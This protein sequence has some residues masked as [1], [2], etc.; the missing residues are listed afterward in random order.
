LGDDSPRRHKAHEV[1]KASALALSHEVIG[2]AIEVHRIIGPGLL[3]SVYEVALCRELWLRG[4][5]VDRQVPI[6]VRY[7]GGV[8]DCEIRPDLVVNQQV[9]VEV[10]TV[11]K[12]VPLHTSQLLTYL[13]MQKLWLGLLK[14]FNVDLLRNGIKG[15]LNG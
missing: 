12:L 13:R 14:N 7:K 4:L 10:K 5:R 1:H 8:L 6:P 15:V 9:I 2:A 3:E 11:E